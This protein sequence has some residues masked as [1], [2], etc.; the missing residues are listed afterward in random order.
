V[1]S[2][3]GSRNFSCFVEILGRVKNIEERVDSYH[4]GNCTNIV[5][6]S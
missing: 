1:R 5:E 3:E 2:P 6:K 4:T